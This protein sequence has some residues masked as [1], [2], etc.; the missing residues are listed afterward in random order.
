[1]VKILTATY[2]G[3]VLVPSVPTTLTQ[4]IAY[5]ITL[6]PITELDMI[7]PQDS[8]DGEAITQSLNRVYASLPSQLDEVLTKM[9]LN[10][11]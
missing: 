8:I 7:L 2:D 4:N 10:S 9:Q 5:L 11:I 6:Q 1:M 3:K